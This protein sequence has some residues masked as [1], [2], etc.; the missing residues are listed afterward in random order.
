MIRCKHCNELMSCVD[1]RQEWGTYKCE[2]CNKEIR[3][4][5]EEFKR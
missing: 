2:K 1:D 5:Y 4:Y 3:V